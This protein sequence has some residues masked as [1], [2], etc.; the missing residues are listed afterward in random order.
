MGSHGKFLNR[1]EAWSE[2]WLIWQGQ[3]SLGTRKAG[4][5]FVCHLCLFPAG[6]LGQILFPSCLSFLICKWGL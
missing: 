3:N 5:G 2:L 4:C 6:D 1:G